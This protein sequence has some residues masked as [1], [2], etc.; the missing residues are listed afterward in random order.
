LIDRLLAMKL[1][2]V[3]F[4]LPHE[5]V[6][7]HWGE[8]VL[9]LRGDIT[10]SEDVRAAMS[11]IDTVFHLAALVGFGTYETHWNV[12]VEG[13]RNVYDAAVENGTKVM[14]ASSVVV[15]GDQIQT[16][17]C[18]EGLEHGQ[19]QGAYSR[20]KMAQEKL[21]LEYQVGRGMKLV[22]VRPA[23]VYGAGSG[24]WVSMPIVL[25]KANRLTIIGSGTGNA[26]LVHV[27]N[28]V[29][30]FLLAAASPKTE[31][32]VYNASDGLDVSWGRYLTDLADM[33]GKSPLQSVPLEPLLEA[34]RR[35][36]DPE[37]LQAMEGM[38]TL[39]LEILNLMGYPNRFETEK[40]RSELGWQP[41]FSYAQALEEIRVSLGEGD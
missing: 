32:Q 7:D 28:L 38:P 10:N 34:A 4:S 20:A 36:E 13:S 37:K 15:Y 16:K 39:P 40:I 19:Y 3:S 17:S 25:A 24:P 5:A 1:E 22:V 27:A 14:L 12:T 41:T 26:G 23:N 30:A 2:V 21:A 29:E 33:V 6:P 35:H 31:G 9:V 8:R 18:H 11:R